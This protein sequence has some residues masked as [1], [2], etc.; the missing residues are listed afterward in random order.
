[1]AEL[2]TEAAEMNTPQ[3]LQWLRKCQC[4]W[5]VESIVVAAVA[6]DNVEMLQYVRSTDST[7]WANMKT[8]MTT[9]GLL[10]YAGILQALEAADWLHADGTQW[11][12]SLYR[13]I[14]NE[15]TLSVNKYC[16]DCWPLRTVQW[17]MSRGCT[18][19]TWQCSELAA[20]NFCCSCKHGIHIDFC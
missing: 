13:I 20:E 18:W 11:P 7:A 10:W 17:A 14:C 19:G 16:S 1:M 9:A 6:C 5:N 8:N 4:P 12:N 15:H 2:T 3:L